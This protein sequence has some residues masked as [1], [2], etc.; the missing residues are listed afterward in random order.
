MQPREQRFNGL[1]EAHFEAVRRYIWRRDPALADDVVAET[2]LVAWRRLDEIPADAGPWL[3]GVARNI[4]L[5]A[6]RSTRRQQAVA[7]RL[8][9]AAPG[10]LPRES[11]SEGDAVRAALELLSAAD[12]EVLLLYAWDALDRTEIATVLGC[13]KANV[14]LRLHRAR[15]RFTAALGALGS[16]PDPS[17]HSLIRGGASD[18]H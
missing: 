9:E 13:T 12:R 17:I 7:T 18:A 16:D 3:I 6:R 10:T 11:S 5:N 15:R 4:R 2:F 1:H 8:T 14:S